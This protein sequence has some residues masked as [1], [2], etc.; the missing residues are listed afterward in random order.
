MSHLQSDHPEVYQH[1]QDGLHVIRRSD[2]Y[3]AGF[4]SDP[5]IE[6]VLMRTMKTGGGL[7]RGRGMSQQQRLIWLLSMPAYVQK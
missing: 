7:T 3:W 6:Q 5:I 4:Y 2:R 1:F